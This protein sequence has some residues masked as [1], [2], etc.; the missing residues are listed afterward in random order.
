MLKIK[1]KRFLIIALALFIATGLAGCTKKNVEGLVADVNGEG[2]SQEEFDTD[3]NVSKNLYEREYG[4]GYLDNDGDDGRPLSDQLKEMI[5]EKLIMF[6]I[7]SQDSKTLDIDVSE[8]E[9]DKVLAESI[10]S[11]GGEENFEEF[12]EE[13]QIPKEY[14]VESLR[15]ELLIDKHKATFLDS[16]EILDKDA[17]DYFHEHKEYLVVIRASRILTDTEENGNDI[18]KRLNEGE[19]FSSIAALE[20]LDNMSAAQGGDL[21]YFTKGTFSPDIEEVLFSLDKGEVSDLIQT[22]VGYEIFLMEDKKD[23]YDDLKIDIKRLMKEE[24]Y[25][26]EIQKLWDKAK[27]D[28]YMEISE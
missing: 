17:E 7:I 5:L 19:E 16:M 20:S 28:T 3:Y 9:L 24:N 13:S 10:D 8:D 21:G 22:D 1:R 12:L 27:I 4:E 26:I 25:L 18:L 6:K 11:V 15:R 2:I 23:S 14:F